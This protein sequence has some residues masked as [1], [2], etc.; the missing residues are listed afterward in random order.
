M[1]LSI[2]KRENRRASVALS[3]AA[4]VVAIALIASITFHYPLSALFPDRE[5]TLVERITYVVP[6]PAPAGA[7][8]GAA[9]PAATPRKGK[10]PAP[11]VAPVTVPTELP[12]IAPPVA[13]P[14][15]ESGTG[16]GAGGGGNGVGLATGVAPSLP[17][18]RIELRPNTLRMPLTTA[19]RN[20][21]AVKAIYLAYRQAEIEAAARTGRN[22]RDWTI[23]RNGGKYGLDSS[24]IY[25]GKFKIP[26]AILAA[27]PLNTGGV[28]GYR[29][30][31]GRNAAW[32]QN[33]IYTH[34]QGLSEEDFRAAIKR[35]RE[36][37]DREKKEAEEAKAR[38]QRGIVP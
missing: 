10:P 4:H 5:H 35:I 30:I 9:N 8:G 23:E 13:A 20:D 7:A 25:L 21:S 18:P 14:G 19:Q 38:Q 37:T 29:I 24:Y 15:A 27:L 28:A 3:L 1:K 36:R 32:I 12:P 11:L 22:P 16:T 31:E 26:S 2:E 34:A 6:R 33:D 17:D